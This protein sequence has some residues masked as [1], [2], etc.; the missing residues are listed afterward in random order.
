M[1]PRIPLEEADLQQ[2][3]DRR[4]PGQSR[5]TTQRKEPDTVAIAS[6]VFEGETTGTP[7]ALIIENKD[8]DQPSSKDSTFQL[9]LVQVVPKGD[10]PK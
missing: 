1:P 9:G 4:R 2:W 6:G 7:I 3:L 8:V 10:A 5:Y